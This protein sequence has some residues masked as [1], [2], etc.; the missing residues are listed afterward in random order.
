MP[1]VDRPV[2]EVDKVDAECRVFYRYAE[3]PDAGTT[4]SIST[5]CT[6]T[7]NNNSKHGSQHNGYW[8]LSVAFF[9]AMLGV[10]A[11]LELPRPLRLI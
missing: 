5:Y 6:D 3:W 11:P 2:G 1:A 9:I 7:Q 4:L 8:M 10:A